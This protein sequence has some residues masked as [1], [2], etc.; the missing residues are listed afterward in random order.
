MQADRRSVRLARHF[1]GGIPIQDVAETGHVGHGEQL[2]NGD[3][4]HGFRQVAR[5][6]DHRGVS[7][8]PENTVQGAAEGPHGDSGGA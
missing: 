3:Q 4:Q 2:V 1:L 7:G 8:F 6:A 5:V